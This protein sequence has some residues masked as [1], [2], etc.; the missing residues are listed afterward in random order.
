[1]QNIHFSNY[2]DAIRRILQPTS[3]YTTEFYEETFFC[4]IPPGIGL[5]GWSGD[6]DAG[7]K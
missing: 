6:D 5:K 4:A 2:I 7:I 1:M 3:G